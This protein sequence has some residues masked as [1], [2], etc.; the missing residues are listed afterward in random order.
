M[1][2]LILLGIGVVYLV[3]KAAEA[4]TPSTPYRT[5]DKDANVRQVF[6]DNDKRMKKIMKK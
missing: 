6:S 3:I 5:G 4:F 1:P 2:V